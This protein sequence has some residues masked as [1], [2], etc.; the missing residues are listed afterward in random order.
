MLI[1]AVEAGGTKVVLA[2]GTGP[3]EIR[4]T[5]R[6]P[7]TTPGEVTRAMLEFFASQPPVAAFGVASFGPIRLDRAA[8]DWGRLLTTPKPGWS[9]GSFAAPLIERFGVPVAVETD[10]N[11]A[12]LAEQRHGAARG[13]NVVVYVTVGTGIGVGV[14]I[15]G[16]PLHGVLHPE[17]GHIRLVRD[18]ADPF[19]GACPYHGDC[20]EGLAA[21]PAIIARWGESL[22]RL[23]D[24]EQAQVADDLGQGCA[25]IA[26]AYSPGRIV[27]GGGVLG[28]PGLRERVDARM[29]HWLGGYL[30]ELAP[31][32]IAAPALGDR[33]GIVGGIEIARDLLA[34]AS[35]SA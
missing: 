6:I 25:A 10:V 29:R 22:D 34:V 12:A 9:G 16:K 31:D 21:G 19:R 14:V 7:T 15:D 20:L 2:V 27:L 26:L 23:G 18:P 3:E 32:T 28:T 35:S 17:F 24:A 1:G 11:A 4:A 8:P 13:A 33:A 30:H 5:A